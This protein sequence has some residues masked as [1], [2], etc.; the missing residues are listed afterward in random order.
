[1][2]KSGGALFF[3]RRRSVY[4]PMCSASQA[5]SSGAWRK[6]YNERDIDFNQINHPKNSSRNQMNAASHT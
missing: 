3:M 1:M 5:R 6:E 4:G 2:S